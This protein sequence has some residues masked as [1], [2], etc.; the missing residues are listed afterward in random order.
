MFVLLNSSAHTSKKFHSNFWL[1]NIFFFNLFYFTFFLKLLLPFS[2]VLFF[3]LLKR[4][5]CHLN[6]C[7]SV[8]VFVFNQNSFGKKHLEM[9]KVSVPMLLKATIRPQGTW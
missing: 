5:L 3:L 9:P 4:P 8:F 6:T 7:F 2:F 1:L